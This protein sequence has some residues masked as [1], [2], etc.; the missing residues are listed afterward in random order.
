MHADGHGEAQE[1]ER[2]V[3]PK[4]RRTKGAD[5]AAMQVDDTPHRVYVSSL[6]DYLSDSDSSSASD[7]QTVRFSPDL[8]AYLSQQ[9]RAPLLPQIRVAT[10]GTH[11]GERIAEN[12]ELVL[13]GAPTSLTLGSGGE[14][15][16]RAILEARARARASSAQDESH[17]A[18]WATEM[19]VDDG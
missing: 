18:G 6:D 8:K 14:S 10:D 17:G 4:L 9:R 11:A 19:E 5:G 12:R 15:V 13:Y 16:R 3:R 7:S 2:A 1:H